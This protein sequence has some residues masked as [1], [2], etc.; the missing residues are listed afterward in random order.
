MG[1]GLNN[2][3]KFFISIFFLIICYILYKWDLKKEIQRGETRMKNEE[4][5]TEAEIEE[6]NKTAQTK[7]VC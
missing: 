3:S 5:M 1:F 2:N 7:D 6:A 4:F